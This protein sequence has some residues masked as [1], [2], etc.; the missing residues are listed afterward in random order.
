MEINFEKYDIDLDIDFT[1]ND[2][3]KCDVDLDALDDMDYFG[4]ENDEDDEDDDD[5]E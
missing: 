3:P 1:I 4:Y 2:C 5:D